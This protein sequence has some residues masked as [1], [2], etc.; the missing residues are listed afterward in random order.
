MRTLAIQNDHYP[1][2]GSI[3]SFDPSHSSGQRTR[4][5]ISQSHARTLQTVSHT[6]YRSMQ[7]SQERGTDGKKKK[8]RRKAGLF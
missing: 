4:H 6:Q 8:T 7:E 2:V 3:E 5:Y 1:K